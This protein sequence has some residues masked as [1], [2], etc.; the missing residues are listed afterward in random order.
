MPVI[1]KIMCELALDGK[2]SIPIE[3]LGLKRFD[4]DRHVN[5][6]DNS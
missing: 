5:K 2:S 3:F 4:L 1:G 6:K